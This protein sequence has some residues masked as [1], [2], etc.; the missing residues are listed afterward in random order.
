MSVGVEFAKAELAA[1]RL[2]VARGESPVA[3]ITALRHRAHTGLACAA[4]VPGQRREE[5]HQFWQGYCKALRDLERGTGSKL[6]IKDATSGAYEPPAVLQGAIGQLRDDIENLTRA[7]IR[8]RVAAAGIE[9][10]FEPV[11][12]L[13]VVPPSEFEDRRGAAVDSHHE[14]TSA[15]VVEG[16]A[17]RLHPS[18]VKPPPQAAGAKGAAS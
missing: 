8:Q 4:L 13:D 10:P 3:A 6:A 15:R 14:H 2:A 9:L 16:D 7:E 11:T 5:L 1:L 17:A 18:S 12:D